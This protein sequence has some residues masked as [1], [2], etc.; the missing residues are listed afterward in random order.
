[1]LPLI[2]SKCLYLPY[3]GPF[4]R[5]QQTIGLE[6]RF[7][8]FFHH[9]FQV[10]AKHGQVGTIPL[11]R[12]ER[13]I[14]PLVGAFELID[15]YSVWDVPLALPIPLAGLLGCCDTFN[16][17]H[18][19]IRG[20]PESVPAVQEFFLGQ[21]QLGRL[22]QEALWVMQSYLRHLLNGGSVEAERALAAYS[23][24]Q[25]PFWISEESVL[26]KVSHDLSPLERHAFR[27]M[28][29]SNY[30]PCWRG[31]ALQHRSQFLDLLVGTFYTSVRGLFLGEVGPFSQDIPR[32]T[33]LVRSFIDLLC[34]RLE[35]FSS[36]CLISCFVSECF[37]LSG[38]MVESFS[39]R[40]GNIG[41]EELMYQYT[42]WDGNQSIHRASASVE[43]HFWFQ[44]GQYLSEI[45]LC[46]A[47]LTA[48][49]P[50]G[51]VRSFEWPRRPISQV[52]PLL[53]LFKSLFS[54]W[55]DFCHSKILPYVCAYR[56][57]FS[58]PPSLRY[59][60]VLALLQEGKRD[61]VALEIILNQSE[62]DLEKE[63]GAFAFSQWLFPKLCPSERYKG[64]VLSLL[65][66][67]DSS[68]PEGGAILS[69]SPS[70]EMVKSWISLRLCGLTDFQLGSRE[71]L[72][73]V[74]K[75]GRHHFIQFLKGLPFCEESLV[76]FHS[77][78]WMTKMFLKL[79]LSSR[80][81]LVELLDCLKLILAVSRI[82]HSPG[83]HEPSSWHVK[84]SLL[85][86][87]PLRL[88]LEAQR[89]H[90]AIHR[91]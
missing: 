50:E 7:P 15:S 19:Y 77:M 76:S 89:E 75:H 17:V 24:S 30:T 1:M 66:E 11:T 10:L 36:P 5:Q 9:L 13:E 32:C 91:R 41:I 79:L 67:L 62:G 68:F 47:F 71:S 12:A 38:L 54:I 6:H 34:A 31:R 42:C 87:L 21:C 63:V 84:I 49:G 3:S 29:T 8:R 16:R 44:R 72:V 22:R 43:W 40:E 83:W 26:E 51:R 4:S 73:R 52:A 46:E 64:K 56:R 45:E 18:A 55:L 60:S 69:M 90:Q 81:S 20:S 14:F 59:C 74:V 86:C 23:F 2:G 28:F 39:S 70:E 61:R 58:T 35:I 57:Q 85:F 80:F 25:D 37:N 65:S 33:A 48:Y 82:R 27:E 53:P 88:I 78:T